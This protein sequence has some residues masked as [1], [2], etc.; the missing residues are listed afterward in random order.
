MSQGGSGEIQTNF[1]KIQIKVNTFFEI[2]KSIYGT[3]FIIEDHIVRTYVSK[4]IWVQIAHNFIIPSSNLRTQ[5]GS[6]RIALS[7]HSVLP[8]FPLQENSPYSGTDRL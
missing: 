4:K 8:K 3:P 2:S 1:M 6:F 5:S 7:V